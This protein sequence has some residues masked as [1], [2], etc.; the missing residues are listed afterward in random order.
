MCRRI[1]RFVVLKLTTEVGFR[2]TRE[3]Y[4]EVILGDSKSEKSSWLVEER[5]YE[6]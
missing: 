6:G 4:L 3:R 1:E 2:D 5:T